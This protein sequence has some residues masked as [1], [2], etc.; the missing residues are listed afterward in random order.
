MQTDAITAER[1]QS[2]GVSAFISPIQV[3]DVA[4]V[5]ILGILLYPL[6][7]LA[8]LPL[9]VNFVDIFVA[10]WFGTAVTGT[11]FAVI[12]A[13][14][15]LP[16]RNTLIPLGHRFLKEKGRIAV[17]LVLAV[18]MFLILGPSLGF[19]L[20]IDALAVA[21]LLLRLRRPLKEIA[22]DLLVPAAYLFCEVIFVLT[23]NHAI[24]G[25]RN[26]E[27][28][29]AFLN[30]A[31][32]VLFGLQVSTLARQ[33]LDHLP[34]LYMQTLQIAYFGMF[35]TIG[36][37][38][39]FL[40][41]ASGRREAVRLVRTIFI[42]SVISV[43]VYACM[44]A[45]GPW[46]F[47]VPHQAKDAF[48][49]PTY[50]TQQMIVQRANLLWSHT[51][52]TQVYRADVTDA[53]VSFPSLHVAVPLIAIWFL[54]GYRRMFR[55]GAAVYILFLV[56]SVV[57]LEWHYIVDVAGGIVVAVLAIWISSLLTDSDAEQH[58]SLHEETLDS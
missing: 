34:H 7:R 14:I 9:A 5:L 2:K 48:L 43:S 54:R 51:Y 52:S 10:I 18:M 57:L 30:H 13:A 8:H 29:D 17:T 39:I 4:L 28:F 38:L 24:P 22:F 3:A 36:G 56:P 15:G 21:E 47:S 26:P 46:I 53:F 16:G 20:T 37:T 35:G 32:K 33:C 58:F 25:I 6:Y 45:I 50:G 55:A 11:F 42:C 41:I 23:Y 12:I 27:S 19:V 49:L 1:S 44:P 40:A 31:D